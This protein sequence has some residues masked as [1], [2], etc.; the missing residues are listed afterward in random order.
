MILLDPRLPLG[1]L[2]PRLTAAPYVVVV[3]GAEVTVPGGCPGAGSSAGGCC[4][5]PRA[6]SPRGG[7]RRARRS[8]RPADALPAS[9]SR[10]ASTSSGSAA[11]SD[12][13]RRA[14]RRAFGLDPDRPLVLGVSRLVPRKGFDVL[15]DAVAGLARRRSSRSP[16]PD[17]TGAASN[18]ARRP[19]RRSPTGCGSSGGSPTTTLPALYACADVFA[20]PCRDRW[21]GL[22]A[23]GFGIVFLE[24]AAAGVPAVAGR[25]GGSHEAVVDGETGFVVDGRALDVQ[26]RARRAAGRRRPAAAHGRRGARPRGHASSPTTTLAA[27]LAPVVAGDLAGLG[28]L[29]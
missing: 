25:S 2:G 7:T 26:R 6:S 17:A 12:A 10:R 4:A 11:R 13:E 23:E 16:A 22:E 8:A 3:H 19:A 24:A 27:R 18:A 14:T 1:Q 20:M 9:W 5:A 15:I 28:P 29:T 21:G